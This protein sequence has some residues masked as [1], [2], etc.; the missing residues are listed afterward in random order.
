MKKC[1]RAWR[2]RGFAGCSVV[3]AV[4][5]WL[6]FVLPM[7]AQ[8][9]NESAS[10]N[11]EADDVF[12]LGVVV[13]R[14]NA[15]ADRL[16][17]AEQMETS[18]T[19]TEIETFEK[20][21]IGT[22]LARTP[23]IRYGHP[24]GG[25]Y[26]SGVV[27]RGFSAFGNGG[28]GV[29][30]FVD[31]IPVYVPYDYS[32][33]MGRFTT[34]GVS[35]ISVSKG[36]SSVLYG[37]NALGGA[38]NVVSQRPSKP[39]Y[40]NFVVG[41]GSGNVTETNGIFGTLQDKWYAQVGLSYLNREF[42]RAAETY[43]G[44][45]ALGQEKDTD[46]KNYG[47]RD[48][49]MEFKFG[50]IPNASDEYVVSYIQQTGQKGPKREPSSCSETNPECW[51]LGYMESWWE[52]PYWDR[53]TVSFVS[54]TNFK[55]FY[56]KPR[57]F[58]DKYD[59]GLYGWGNASYEQRDREVSKYDDYAWG[60]SMEIGTMKIENNTLKGKFDYKFDQHQA[61]SIADRDGGRV[62]NKNQKMEEQIFFF[63]VEDT[64]SFNRQW[65][66][67]GGILYSR[68]TTTYVGSGLNIDGLNVAY[69]QA[70]LGINSPS[71]DSWDPQA[72][73]LYSP[74]K[75]HS[76][77]YSISKKTF[78]PSIRI[79]Y[80]NYGEGGVYSR[81]CPGVDGDCYLVTIPNPDLKPEKALHHEIGWN[82]K[83][84]NRLDVDL[85]WYYSRH[86][87]MIDRPSVD[88]STYPGFAVQQVANVPGDTRR[89]GFDLGAQYTATDRIYVGTSF[90]YLHSINKDTPDWRSTQPAYNGSVYAN[91]GLN[92][93][94]ALIPAL[95]YYGRSRVGSTGANRWNFNRGYA[96]VDL[97]LSITPPMHKNVS[98]NIGAE[99]LFDTDYR[100]WG[101]YNGTNLE[102]YPTPGR[103]LYANV[104]YRL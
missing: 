85:A 23:G 16:N 91:I 99:N 81:G 64:Y 76:F 89:Q 72:A 43:T 57:V 31:G 1:T 32:M 53:E 102:R 18:V 48:K 59:N 41:S 103:Y 20:K 67:Q 65:E 39:L 25:R 6:L 75:N 62:P 61:Y 44:A 54:N 60:A 87:D 98:I 74:N 104:R 46:R 92:D 50:F 3:A 7:N 37:P 68:R 49:K 83:F 56:I 35:A 63:A 86:N 42:I 19:R 80:S 45:D 79:Q 88:T 51:A 26:E 36:Y 8:T 11:E 17:V 12:Q 58:Y 38:I 69:P 71:I 5:A 96:L 100:G 47:T 22:A 33:D 90:N 2:R 34:S 29:P 84:I 78:F 28:V 9:A 21:D 95:D 4:C 94:A 13:F 15:Y 55:N 97:K 101:T 73:L 30:L 77:H 93:W 66:I 24:G 82:G 40:G 14:V 52:W 27:V 10:L 70:D